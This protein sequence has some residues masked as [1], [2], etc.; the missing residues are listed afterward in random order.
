[1]KQ[2]QKHMEVLFK[3]YTKKHIRKTNKKKII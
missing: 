1:M 2:Y 3:E